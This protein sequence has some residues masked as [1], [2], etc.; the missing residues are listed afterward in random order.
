MPQR[1][2]LECFAG[3]DTNSIATLFKMKLTA[4][5]VIDQL[6][7]SRLPV[8]V[9]FFKRTYLGDIDPATNSPTTSAILALYSEEPLS[10]SIFHK[11]KQDE[12]WHF[13][14]GDP[15]QLHLIYPDG[16][17]RKIVLGDDITHHQFLIPRNVWQAGELVP[18]GSWGLFGC[19]LTPGFSNGDFIGGRKTELLELCPSQHELIEKLALPDSE[20][21][22]MPQE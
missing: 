15:I 6:D 20:L 5:E 4:Q 11:L 10:H 18:G 22:H 9:A 13:Y 7:M 19:T 16:A 2:S 17:Y 14:T 12:M 1:E 8:E 21:N 3:S